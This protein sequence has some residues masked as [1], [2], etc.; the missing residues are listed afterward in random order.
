MSQSAARIV[1]Q[2]RSLERAGLHIED[3]IA[4]SRHHL[5]GGLRGKIDEM[6]RRLIAVIVAASLSVA[7]GVDREGSAGL[8]A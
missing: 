5:A 1:R 4:A 2:R 7:F 3:A 8:R 6:P